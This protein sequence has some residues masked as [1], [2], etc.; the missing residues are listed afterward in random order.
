MIKRVETVTVPSPYHNVFSVL[1]SIKESIENKACEVGL[2]ESRKIEMLKEL[3][4][5][6]IRVRV[7][8]EDLLQDVFD[9]AKE[10][11]INL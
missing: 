2:P 10:M 8:F 4:K 9:E 3:S 7:R 5:E 1:W 6:I 11:V